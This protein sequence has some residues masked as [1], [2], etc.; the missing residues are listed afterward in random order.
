MLNRAR[1][2]RW[3]TVFCWSLAIFSGCGPKTI[4]IDSQPGGPSDYALLL[5]R[6]VVDDKI[7]FAALMKNRLLLD[8]YLSWMLQIELGSISAHDGIAEDLLARLINCH[9]AL[10]L[11]SLVTLAS[12]G[13][14]PARLP[15]DLNRRFRFSIGS[16]RAP[17]LVPPMSAETFASWAA[18]GDWRVRLA[19]YNG[20]RDGPPLAKRP[21]LGNLLDAQLDAATRAALE[22]DQIVRIDYG[23]RKQLL[24]WHGLYA[25]RQTMIDDYERRVHTEGATLLSVLLEWS[26]AFRRETLNSAV[27]YPVA[28]MPRD[29][30]INALPPAERAEK[31]TR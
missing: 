31:A 21:F 10:M 19:L 14:L 28:A 20:C 15:T 25:V 5:H 13:A 9:N 30:R 6:I 7:D 1:Y 18:A 22:S 3:P 24:L 2:L 4:Q 11:R 17:R 16:G 8:R 27:G 12:D 23:E 29:R 26:D